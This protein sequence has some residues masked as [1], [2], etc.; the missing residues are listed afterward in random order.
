[1]QHPE[2]QLRSGILEIG[3][4][5]PPPHSPVTLLVSHNISDRN[6]YISSNSSF[7]KLKIIKL[8]TQEMF[9]IF[10]QLYTHSSDVTVL[11]LEFSHMGICKCVSW[12]TYVFTRRRAISGIFRH[13][14][15]VKNIYLRYSSS[16]MMLFYR[17]TKIAF[18]VS[19]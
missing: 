10:K 8:L 7:N 2:C 15:R 19:G 17:H 6:S 16:N 9:E 12:K 5:Y 13:L 18:K 11:S 14:R 3:W 4:K 1:M